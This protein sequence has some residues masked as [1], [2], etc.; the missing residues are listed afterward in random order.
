MLCNCEV[1]MLNDTQLLDRLEALLRANDNM[2]EFWFDA[3]AEMLFAGEESGDTL[4]E[5]LQKLVDA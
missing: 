4:R 3:D 2:I 5:A 1:T